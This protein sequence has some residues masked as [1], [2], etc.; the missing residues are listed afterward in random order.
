MGLLGKLR[1]RLRSEMFLSTYLGIVVNPFHIIRSGLHTEIRK[2]SPQMNG[3]V[4]DFGC[5]SK[6]YQG[7]FIN[8][9]KYIGVD[10]EAS[11]HNH[12]TS[13]V[14]F[15]YDGKTLPFDSEHFD[16]VVSFETLEHVFELDGILSELNRVI[17]PGGKLLISVPFVWDEHEVPYDFARYTSFGVRHLLSK[18]GFEV[19]EYRKTTTYLLTVF[20]MFIAYLYQHV[21]P[22]NRWLRHVFQLIFVFPLNLLALGLDTIFPKNTIFL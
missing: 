15:F 6:P 16:G 19:V 10:I 20:Q 1:S 21:F 8:A 4:L 7:L 13:K 22:S 14:D 5:G 9:E 3:N 17:K 18:H 12:A 11:G 2:I